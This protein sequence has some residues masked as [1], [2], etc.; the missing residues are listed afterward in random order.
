MG[1]PTLSSGAACLLLWVF[2]VR[3]VQASVLA[4]ATRPYSEESTVS[5]L[6]APLPSSNAADIRGV[7]RLDEKSAPKKVTAE[8]AESKVDQNR[9]TVE[10]GK[11]H[12]I[13]ESAKK[14]KDN[15]YKEKDMTT[16]LVTDLLQQVS[17]PVHSQMEQ[18]LKNYDRPSDSG[19]KLPISTV[20]PVAL[21]KQSHEEKDN[22]VQDS[23][24]E[25]KVDE[26]STANNL[27]KSEAEKNLAEKHIQNLEGS[28][29]GNQPNVN[30]KAPPTSVKQAT[31]G[32]LS[33]LTAPPQTGAHGTKSPLA[34]PPHGQVQK[35]TDASPGQTKY[36]GGVPPASS[37]GNLDYGNARQ[38]DSEEELEPPLPSQKDFSVASG[39]A[40][41][42]AQPIVGSVGGNHPEKP[43]DASGVAGSMPSLPTQ[44]DS[45]F[46]AYFLTA[47]VL[48][49]VGYLAFH[50]KR[51][52]LALILEGRHERQRRHNGH[53]R[54]LDNTDEA[55]SARKSRGSF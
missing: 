10:D 2:V 11:V 18:Q 26:H 35:N 16:N 17:S 36:L 19:K 25:V 22:V 54:R 50:N 29:G 33:T 49:V 12:R 46:F 14:P 13:R 39:S 1:V 45:H 5:L 23:A 44:D 27:Q 51:K 48:C 41:L 52:I 55:S 34:Q 21:V 31:K 43:L 53:Y 40:S 4:V 32:I 37:P 24:R 30:P 38:P 9:V 8:Q 15:L 28:A 6:V 47:V 20:L 3:S 42:G 7:A